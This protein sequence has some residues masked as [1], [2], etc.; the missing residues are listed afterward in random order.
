MDNP[1][2]NLMGSGGTG[3]GA[4]TRV[5]LH[6]HSR[7]SNRASE[8][9]LQGLE[10]PESFT[11][12]EE[13]WR[14][15]RAAGMRFVTI[16]DHNSV[17]GA[18]AIAHLPDTFLSSEVTVRFPADGCEIHCLVIGVSEE[19]HREV[20]RRRGNL[21]DFRDYLAQEK[22]LYSVAH[23][24]YRVNGL[25]TLD[26]LE[27]LLV[28]FDRF[29]ARNGIH[30]R[31]S[32]DLVERLVGALTP[33]ILAIMADRHGLEPAGPTPWVKA[34]TGGSDDHG[35]F[36][37]ATTYTETPAAA[38][39]EELL[40]HLRTGASVP[41]GASGSTRRLTRSLY[42]IG[43]DYCQG[44]FAAGN[45]PFQRTL[46]ALAGRQRRLTLLVPPLVPPWLRRNGKATGIPVAESA[47]A[48]EERAFTRAD[49][50]VRRSLRRFLSRVAESGERGQ[51]G[52][53][54]S[55]L[56]ELAPAV[57]A[58]TPLVAALRAQ[59]KDRDLERQV[60][61][62]MGLCPVPERKVWI[63]DTLTEVNGVARTIAGVTAVARRQGR[64]ISPMVCRRRLPSGLGPVHRFEPLI[65]VPLPGYPA[66]PL[67]VPSP[68]AVLDELEHRGV[69]DLLISTPGPLGL[70]ALLAGGLLGIRRT[71]IYHTDFPAYL[72]N[73]S[74]DP[75]LE[76]VAW[77]YLA[78]FYGQMDRI[79]VPSRAYL[80]QLALRGL[81]R[82]R[83]H[84]MSR[85]VDRE[86]FH[87][88]RRDP[89]FWPR[90]GARRDFRFLYAGRLSPE[91]N[92]ELL[93]SA[94]D[95]FVASGRRATLAVVGDGP[96][97]AALE[98]QAGPDVVFT[99][100]LHG[101]ELATAYAS[102][103]VFVFPSVTD[104]FGNAV[105]EAQ[106]SGLP[107]LVTDQGGPQEIVSAL[108]SG[109]VLPATAEAFAVAMAELFD[110]PDH[111]LE[112]SRRAVLAAAQRD[113]G[114]F[115]DALFRSEPPGPSPLQG[116]PTVRPARPTAVLQA[117]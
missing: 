110:A 58:L 86:L 67:A 60:A 41:G 19:Q 2:R 56:G 4:S 55:S 102:A 18:L 62:R 70:A 47:P 76:E 53:A 75:S 87:P 106:A 29:E 23:P 91:K 54:L 116:V 50:Q 27:Q 77:R 109:A 81:E 49:R 78:W 115:L 3:P 51:L 101:E 108:G 96:G 1:V 24:L 6:V 43:D 17:D 7:Y 61:Q 16:S 8:W 42:A 28:L 26:H 97:R 39:V 72:R 22:I 105:L 5:D 107:A 66:L 59:S 32:N 30:H 64:E 57:A 38:S 31:R 82:S 45:D 98:R 112:L 90:H 93:L 65:E 33:E 13:V 14:R 100:F 12:P 92:L 69:T 35:G 85:G 11:A 15:C 48:A 73:L 40:A 44:R 71:G 117:S 34:V 9:Y 25:L 68:F 103:D 10:A 37:I 94:F 113:W 104:T 80:E 83:L 79:F 74:G 36:Y 46:A 84:L 52:R 99:G 88:G 95:R 21:Y 111:C 20:L 63:S 114:P 89:G